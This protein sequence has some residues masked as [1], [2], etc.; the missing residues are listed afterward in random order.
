MCQNPKLKIYVG[1]AS[2]LLILRPYIPFFFQIEEWTCSSLVLFGIPWV[3]VRI[4]FFFCLGSKLNW[5][6]LKRGVRGC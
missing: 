6:N 4:G 3:L 2:M 1:H 5:I